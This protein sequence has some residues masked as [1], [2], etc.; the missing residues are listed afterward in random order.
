MAWISVLSQAWPAVVTVQAQ[1]TMLFVAM[2]PGS[3][4]GWNSAAWLSKHCPDLNAEADI[5]H[6]CSE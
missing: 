2:L 5:F 4:T 1:F 6:C 3:G